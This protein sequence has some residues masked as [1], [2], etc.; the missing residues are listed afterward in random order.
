TQIDPAA[1]DNAGAG[2][3]WNHLRQYPLDGTFVASSAGFVYRFAGGAPIYVSSWNAVGG[4]QPATLIDQAAIDNA[5]GASPWNHVHKY[6]ADGTFV[7]GSTGAV[8]PAAGGAPTP[9]SGL[10][11]L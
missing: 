4:S 7:A 10:T 3:V 5:D 1:I 8:Y 2:G 11:A 6:P 9:T